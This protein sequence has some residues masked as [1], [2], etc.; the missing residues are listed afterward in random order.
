[1]SDRLYLTREH[2]VVSKPGFDATNSSLAEGDK[3]FDSDWLFSST[4]VEVG[5]HYDQSNYTNGRPPQGV[6][7]WDE[8]TDWTGPQYIDFTPLPFVPTVLLISLSDPRYWGNHGMVLLGA[9]PLIRNRP[10]DYW[11]TGTITVTNSRIT[12]PRIRHPSG[13]Y[14]ES[15]IY[16]IMA[17]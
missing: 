10:D 17:M 3:L 1:M 7:R 14:R 2:L 9:E 5:I 11:R 6:T 15:F 4:I 13:C 8:W 16:L 12:I